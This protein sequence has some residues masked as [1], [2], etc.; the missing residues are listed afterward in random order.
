MK[1]GVNELRHDGAEYAVLVYRS[2][3]KR[4]SSRKCFPVHHIF[5]DD[6]NMANITNQ[7]DS[8]DNQTCIFKYASCH[9]SCTS[10]EGSDLFQILLQLV[11]IKF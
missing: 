1:G 3:K 4:N 11:F 8:Y 10:H 7:Y 6:A 9:N 2:T 5:V